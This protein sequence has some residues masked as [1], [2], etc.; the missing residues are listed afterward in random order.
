MRA[1]KLDRRKPILVT[2]ALPYANGPCHLGHLRTYVPGDAFVR[3]LRKMKYDVV[4][5][6]GSDAH[7]TPIVVEA[8]KAGISP[9][10]LVERYHKRFQD[11]FRKIGI[12]FDYYGCTHDETNHN[13]TREIIEALHRNGYIYEAETVQYYCPSCKKFLADRYIVGMCPHC[14]AEARG[15]E[16]DQG[17]G[18]YLSPGEVLNPRCAFCGMTPERK[19]VRHAFFKLSAFEGFLAKFIEQ[20]EITPNARGLAKSWLSRGLRDWCITRVLNWGVRYPRDPSLV[21][22]VWVDAPI[23]YISFTEDWSKISG[24][25]WEKFWKRG[26]A[27]IIHFIGADIAYH[28]CIFWPAML[29]GAGYSLPAAIL[30]HG[31]LTINGMPFSKTRGNVV[32]VEQDLLDKGIDPDAIRYFIL[33]STSFTRDLD[34]N[35]SLLSSKVNDEL[36]GIFG[37][38]VNRALS[39]AYRYY[40]HVPS[41]ELEEEVLDKIR[42][43]ME[44]FKKTLNDLDLRHICTSFMSLAS[45]GNEYFQS[46][47]PWVKF[48]TKPEECSATIRNC[49]QITKALA[50]LSEP[51]MPA[52]ARAIWEMLGLEGDVS[53]VSLEACLDPLPI[54]LEIQKPKLLFKKLEAK[55]LKSIDEELSRRRGGRALGR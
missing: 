11:V 16:C 33:S 48:K 3:L 19:A 13:R 26:E 40:G 55:T 30:A 31:M 39:F 37:N 23:G 45:F 44:E 38:Y 49:L 14:G 22:Y 24:I 9:E 20:T 17:C 53:S 35:T 36:I 12:S 25:P 7:G 27:T 18:R 42:E 4:F 1:L 41:G 29:K 28:H 51:A 52:K 8:E 6:C 34:F 5:I 10:K 47:E 50:V 43:S 2:C 15:D 54:G 32:W 21:V 46:R